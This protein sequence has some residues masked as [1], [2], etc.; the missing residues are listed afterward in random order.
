ML[1]RGSK[2]PPGPSSP[3]TEDLTTV[4][5]TPVR[6]P[7]PPQCTEGQSVPNSPNRYGSLNLHSH[8]VGPNRTFTD[9]ETEAQNSNSSPGGCCDF[10]P[11]LS[12]KRTPVWNHLVWLWV[13]VSPLLPH[14]QS[15]GSEPQWGAGG[16]SDQ[17]SSPW[18]RKRD[19]RGGTKS[20]RLG[21]CRGP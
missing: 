5:A 6:W 21:A 9:A 19:D 15:H 2:E 10:V 13:S 17:L 3:G 8:T 16:Q 20:P 14:N 1:L 4:F 18:R 12:A 11:G 7:L